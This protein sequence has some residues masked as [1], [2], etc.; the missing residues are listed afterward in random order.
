M[1]IMVTWLVWLIYLPTSLINQGEQGALNTLGLPLSLIYTGVNTGNPNIQ[2]RIWE[3]FIQGK[4]L[5]RVQ[6]KKNCSSERNSLWKPSFLFFYLKINTF[7]LWF[8]FNSDLRIYGA[9]RRNEIDIIKQV[10]KIPNCCSG[11]QPFN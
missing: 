10:L 5:V 6:L 4:P 2:G 1:R 9:V 3:N 11:M 8:L 7:Q